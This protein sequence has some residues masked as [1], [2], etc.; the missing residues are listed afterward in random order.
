MTKK[1]LRIRVANQ[2]LNA[3]VHYDTTTNFMFNGMCRA[4]SDVERTDFS[5]TTDVAQNVLFWVRE[6]CYRRPAFFFPPLPQHKQRR[7]MYLLMC[8]ELV[9]RNMLPDEAYAANF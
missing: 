5:P 2:L 1:Q 7:V 9:R 3:A 8:A 4:L 6:S